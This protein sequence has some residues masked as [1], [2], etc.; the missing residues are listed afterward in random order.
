MIKTFSIPPVVRMVLF[1][2]FFIMSEIFALYEPESHS[3]LEFSI[4]FWEIPKQSDPNYSKVRH[5]WSTY[6]KYIVTP[7]WKSLKLP[8]SLPELSGLKEIVFQIEWTTIVRV[9]ARNFVSHIWDTQKKI[10][11]AVED[12]IS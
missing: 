5:I 10:T 6:P 12:K 3:Y 1:F 4:L 2:I 11:D 7:E 9:F 8:S